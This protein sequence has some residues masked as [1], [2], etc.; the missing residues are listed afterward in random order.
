VDIN[1]LHGGRHADDATANNHKII[2]PLNSFALLM[3]LVV[4]SGVSEIATLTH[5]FTAQ[6]R[7]RSKAVATV[8]P[9]QVVNQQEFA[10]G[11][12]HRKNA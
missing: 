8:Q 10:N 9:E 12:G 1:Q 6:I 7:V 5:Q 2:H 4:V 11:N 3:R